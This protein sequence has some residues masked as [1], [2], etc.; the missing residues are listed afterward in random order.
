M[1]TRDGT[2]WPIVIFW[3][4]F[5]LAVAALGAYLLKATREVGA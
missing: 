2:A 4:G 5:A 1:V 3:V